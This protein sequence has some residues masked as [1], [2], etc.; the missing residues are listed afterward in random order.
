M[1]SAN[2][3]PK[4]SR[5]W[6]ESRHRQTNEKNL[7]LCVFRGPFP[8]EEDLNYYVPPDIAY[9]T[10]LKFSSQTTKQSSQ[11]ELI[12]IPLFKIIKEARDDLRKR[13]EEL[14]REHS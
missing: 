7:H 3:F 11:E 6:V 1:E 2:F 8:I 10:D 13:R 12:E 5:W 14:L 9:V 4:Y